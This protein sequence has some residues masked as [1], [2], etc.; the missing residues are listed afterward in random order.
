MRLDGGPFNPYSG[1]LFADDQRLRAT[2]S[3]ANSGQSVF[4]LRSTPLCFLRIAEQPQSAEV[5]AGQRAR[6]QVGAE[7]LPGATLYQ[8]VRIVAGGPPMAVPGADGP[9]F[10]T[11]PLNLNDNGSAYACFVSNGCENAMSQPAFVFVFGPP[12]LQ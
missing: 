7:G 1:A 10:T 2:N 4:R 8:W 11:E 9:E 3:T 5:P 6:F 12:A